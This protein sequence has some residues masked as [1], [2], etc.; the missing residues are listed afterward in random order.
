MEMQQH[1]ITFFSPGTFVDE[2]TTL[3][4]D[5]WD[6]VVGKSMAEKSRERHGA[7][8]YAFQFT[9]RGRRQDELDSKVI[10]T[11]PRYFI[12]GKVRT[13]E[14]VAADADP[15][16]HILLRNMENNDI[17][18]VVETRNSWRHTAPMMPGD[19]VLDEVTEFAAA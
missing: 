17:A 19:V 8:P 7:K 14:Q 9:T 3:P 6:P 2:I 4:V 11:S 1:F 10:A 13:L 16:E 15:N 5:A 18:R 12:R